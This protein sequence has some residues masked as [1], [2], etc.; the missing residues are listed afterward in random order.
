MGTRDGSLASRRAVL[1][2]RRPSAAKTY[3]G[4]A[5]PHAPSGGS[6]TSFRRLVGT[7]LNHV[8]VGAKWENPDVNLGSSNSLADLTQVAETRGAESAN[9][10]PTDRSETNAKVHTAPSLA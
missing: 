2:R 7:A 4:N 3:L 1:A 10:T 9:S 5:S 8:I 6:R